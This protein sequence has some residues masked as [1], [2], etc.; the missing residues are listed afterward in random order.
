MSKDVEAKT[1][2]PFC[3]AQPL[4]QEPDALGEVSRWLAE[5]LWNGIRS[6]ITRRNGKTF[7][8]SSDG[9]LV[10][11]LFPELLA[12]AEL[13]PDG[14][15]IDGVILAWAEGEVLPVELLQKRS[16]CN[17]PSP[18]LVHEIPVAFMAFDILELDGVDIRE[19]PLSQR[20]RTLVQLLSPGAL[21]AYPSCR[22]QIN[23]SFRVSP[24]LIVS[25]WNELS[26]SHTMS[27]DLK[28][29]GIILKGAESPYA[30]A[31]G[32]CDWWKWES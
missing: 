31:N 32:K 30:A 22:G 26:E 20:R 16:Q 5:W 2:Y 27:R 18:D 15:A 9:E 3:L 10:S 7:I 4:V 11:E 1:P 21:D 6:Q 24:N 12:A 17:N 8:W 28:V 23:S 25:S 13:L 14:T 29:A 19:K